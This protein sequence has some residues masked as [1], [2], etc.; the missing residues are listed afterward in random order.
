MRMP[1]SSFTVLTAAERDLFRLLIHTVSGIGPKLAL[2]VLSG[3]S[4][5]GFS[6]AVASADVKSL[7]GIS[8]VGKDRGAD[9][10]GIEGQ[11]GGKLGGVVAATGAAGVS[12]ASGR[13]GPA[14]GCRGP[15]WCPSGSSRGRPSPP[16]GLRS[17]C[18]AP[19]LRWNRLSG[20]VSV[21]P[22]DHGRDSDPV[23]PRALSAA[24]TFRCR[25]HWAVGFLP[26]DWRGWWPPPSG[27]T[28]RWEFDDQAVCLDRAAVSRRSSPSGIIVNCSRPGYTVGFPK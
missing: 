12:R 11:T 8:G 14:S 15:R 4:V 23:R 24:R 20:P 26:R 7:A 17:R 22:R 5:A 3:M 18:S 19:T 6:R 10:D 25:R 9:R 16:P 28:L 2:N 13:G 21:D 27:A 1:T